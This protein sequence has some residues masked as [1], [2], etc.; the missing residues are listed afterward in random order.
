M[1]NDNK[2]GFSPR[3][4][5]PSPPQNMV[6]T[7]SRIRRQQTLTVDK[8]PG[9]Q[10]FFKPTPKAVYSALAL[11][12]TF[13][14]SKIRAQREACENSARC[15]RYSAFRAG[16]YSACG[17]PRHCTYSKQRRTGPATVGIAMSFVLLI[18]VWGCFRTRSG[19]NFVSI[20]EAVKFCD[21][22]F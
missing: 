12:P 4:P 5:K 21:L 17:R 14:T 6:H 3:G 22:T 10:L 7:S 18:S 8:I 1:T 16:V 15:H 2:S 20:G 11:P 13:T 9:R 19:T